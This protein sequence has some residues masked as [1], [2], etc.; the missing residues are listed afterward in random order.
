MNHKKHAHAHTPVTFKS[1][2]YQIYDKCIT[3]CVSFSDYNLVM[4]SIFAI[5]ELDKL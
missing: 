1:V 2:K 3:L 5:L 4:I